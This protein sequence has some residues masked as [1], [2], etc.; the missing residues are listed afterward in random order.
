MITFLYVNYETSN[1]SDRRI[2]CLHLQILKR[3]SVRRSHITEKNIVIL[4]HY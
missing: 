1:K 4:E 2:T 3:I